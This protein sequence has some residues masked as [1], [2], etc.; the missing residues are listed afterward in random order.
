MK[1]RIAIVNHKGG[2]CKTT[3][4]VNLAAALAEQ[5]KGVLLIDL[6]PQATATR[7]AGVGDGTP[8]AAHFILGD[9]RLPE[10]AQASTLP[11]VQLI[12]SSLKPL[13]DLENRL[14]STIAGE[15]AL[16]KAFKRDPVWEDYDYILIDCPPNIGR[17]S[18]AAMVAA[19]EILV[20]V[21]AR[22]PSLEAMTHLLGWISQDSSGEEIFNQG[23][24]DTVREDLNADLGLCGILVCRCNERKRQERA[25]L[26]EL[27]NDPRLG[28]FV[29]RTVIRENVDLSEAHGNREP[30]TVYNPSSRGA[31]DYRALAAEVIAQEEEDGQG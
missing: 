3:T 19:D 31:E 11:G 12:A 24:Y 22:S 2:T 21:D 27:R 17:L 20:P 14:R 9:V 28:A 18:I 5:G 29:F 1:R 13:D 16:E 30:I 7:W 6:D 26:E 15:K 25:V 4:A 23:T 10:C 8:T